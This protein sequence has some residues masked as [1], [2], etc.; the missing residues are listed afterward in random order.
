MRW[1]WYCCWEWKSTDVFDG[2]WPDEGK[3]GGTTDGKV[4]GVG[5]LNQTCG[6]TTGGDRTVG[7]IGGCRRFISRF[8]NGFDCESWLACWEDVA[9]AGAIFGSVSCRNVCVSISRLF[10]KP[11][12]CECWIS[13]SVIKLT[14]IIG[15][16]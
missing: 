4:W 7:G 9:T 13:K 2:R 3:N 16:C 12:D 8:S 14:S 15:V 10:S 11:V 6:A 1:F 5:E